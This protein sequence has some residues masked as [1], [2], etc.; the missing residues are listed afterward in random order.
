MGASWLH[1]YFWPM[2][3][4]LL[5]Q[6][7]FWAEVNSSPIGQISKEVLLDLS[8][9][10]EIQERLLL[11]HY[12]RGA[13]FAGV[14]MGFTSQAKMEQMGVNDLIW[15][16]LTDK[17]LVEDGGDAYL[18]RYCHARV[19]PEIC[20]LVGKE[21]DRE[22]GLEEAMGH[23]EA[24]APALEIIDSRYK[25]FRFSL[26]DV[27]AD[28]CSAA[29]FVVGQWCDPSERLEG[30][31]IEMHINEVVVERGS[32]SDI[33][34]NP[35]LSVCHASRLALAAGQ[36]LPVGAYIMAGAATAAVYLHKGQR[37]KASVQGMGSVGFNVI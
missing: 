25:D 26:T 23:V 29:G 18:E 21:I 5:A 20:F 16:R 10:Y 9:A 6:K 33:L 27:I 34:G 14:K 12:E 13:K 4:E 37:V 19:E 1:Q 36:A 30:L 28:N 15:G 35:W 32:S 22:L 11:C 31:I 3:A 24:V 17:M 2:N 7:L 8:Q